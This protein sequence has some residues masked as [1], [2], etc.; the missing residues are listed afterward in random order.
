M[1]FSIH[2]VAQWMMEELKQNNYLYQESAV[3][4]IASKFGDDFVYTNSNGN[5]AID[6]KVL[7]AFRKL[8]EDEVVWERGEKAWRFRQ[9]YETG[10]RQ[11]D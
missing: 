7:A 5:Q 4:Q 2:D 8:N 1:S 6:K 3:Y 10:A 9:D 11:Q